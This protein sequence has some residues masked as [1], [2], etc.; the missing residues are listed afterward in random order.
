MKLTVKQEGSA[1]ELTVPSQKEFLQ[2]YRRGVIAPD[3]LV[4]RGEQWVRAGEL[5]WIAG[6]ASDARKDGRRL[7]WITVAMMVLGLL[8]ILWI[9]S[10]AR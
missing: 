5:P 4:Q 10:H 1:Q 2:L 7:T 9:Q 8:G 6:M 3:D